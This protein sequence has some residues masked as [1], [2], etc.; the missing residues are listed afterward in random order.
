MVVLQMCCIHGP[1]QI[2]GRQFIPST[3]GRFAPTG[4]IRNT[5]FDDCDGFGGAPN[6][7]LIGDAASLRTFNEES[8]M[9]SAVD[10]IPDSSR[11][12]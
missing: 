9:M 2:F 8:A 11:T 4:D 5:H 10:R 3:N 7:I 1:S 6:A 12:S